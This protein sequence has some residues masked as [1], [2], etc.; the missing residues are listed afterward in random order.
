MRRTMLVLL[1]LAAVGAARGD[2]RPRWRGPDGNAVSSEKGLPWQWAADKNVRWKTAIPGEGASSPV[3]W[4][5]RVF[6][7]AAL[8]D[9]SQ[10]V[11]HCLDRRDGKITWSRTVHDKD[12]ERTSAVTGH[13]AATPATDGRRVVA[14]FGNAGVVCYDMAGKLL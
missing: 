13:A 5:D 12:P 6:V 11:V 2:N 9:G 10:R 1:L 4:G 14:A 8:K 7:T 3:V